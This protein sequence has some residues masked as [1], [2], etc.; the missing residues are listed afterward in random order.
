VPDQL[1]ATIAAA[2]AADVVVLVLGLNAKI[3]NME[4]QD[5]EHDQAGYALPGEQ[6]TLARKIAALGKPTVAVVLSGM[7]VG[8][9]FLAQQSRENSANPVSENG[10]LSHLYI[11]AIILPRQA[12]DKHREN[13]KKDAVFSG[14]M[15]HLGAWLWRKIWQRGPCRGAL[16]QVLALRPSRLHGEPWQI[17]AVQRRCT[18]RCRDF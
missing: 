7:A 6:V 3:T 18:D 14:T 13:S 10:L 11:N 16:R 2:K 9:D 12:R 5:R 15:E 4:G 17:Q 8:M 1:A